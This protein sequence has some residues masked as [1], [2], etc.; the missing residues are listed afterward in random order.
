MRALGQNPTQQELNDLVNEID[1]NGNSL[2]EFSEFL[3]MMARQIKEQDVEAEILEAFKVFDS[4]GDGKI[5]QTELVRVLTTIGERL[6]EE[7]ARQMLQAADTDS[8]GQIDIEEFAKILLHLRRQAADHAGQRRLD[9][10]D[11]P[12]RQIRE[13]FQVSV[14]ERISGQNGKQMADEA[15]ARHQHAHH[16]QQDE[17]DHRRG[18]R[19]RVDPG[20]FRRLG[21]QIVVVAEHREAPAGRAED[22]RAGE[23][24][25]A[26]Q[27]VRHGHAGGQ[28]VEHDGRVD[29]AVLH[30]ELA[31]GA[32]ERH[33]V[34]QQV[35]EVRVHE[36][37]RR[38]PAQ[39]EVVE[40]PW[41]ERPLV[42]DGRV[43]DRVEVHEHKK[44]AQPGRQRG[45]TLGGGKQLPALV[46]NLLQ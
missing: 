15:R 18:H 33:Q 43:C 41:R 13:P 9:A 6:T 46:G 36:R 26:T 21:L 17:R 3:T 35:D 2:I 4:D 14:S 16:Q 11:D 39:L 22:A 24:K 25:H 34:E 30:L 42:D 29:S 37:V 23:K 10:F 8:D 27:A 7:E 19:H 38:Q 1:T 31:Q 28:E 12:E 45:R 40:R 5:S 32:V 44:H 20:V